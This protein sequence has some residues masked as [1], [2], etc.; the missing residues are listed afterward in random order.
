MLEDA[1]LLLMLYQSLNL[2]FVQEITELQVSQDIQ[3]ELMLWV[4]SHILL[5]KGENLD[6]L[7]KSYEEIIKDYPETKKI[8]RF[9]FSALKEEIATIFIQNKDILPA[10]DYSYDY[11]DKS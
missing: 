11:V 7:I 8:E 10:I 1:V 6:E 9:D 4:I 3:W 2:H 5:A